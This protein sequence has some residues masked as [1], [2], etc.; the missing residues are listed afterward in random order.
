[1]KT[2]STQ[3]GVARALEHVLELLAEPGGFPEDRGERIAHGAEIAS[4]L[5]GQ[6]DSRRESTA[7]RGDN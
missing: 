7:A 6:L 2:W 3:T 1:M 5:V 4:E